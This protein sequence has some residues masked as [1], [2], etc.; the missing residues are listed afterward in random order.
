LTGGVVVVDAFT[1]HTIVEYGLLDYFCVGLHVTIKRAELTQM[2]A[3]LHNQRF[4]DEA[5]EWH[6]DLAASVAALSNVEFVPLSDEG[7][8]DDSDDHTEVR[9]GL[10]AALLAIERNVPLLADDRHCQQACLNVG[11]LPPTHAFGTDVLI[12]ALASEAVVTEDQRADSV[13]RQKDV[14]LCVCARV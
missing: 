12:D 4:C 1:L 5:G 3:E 14:E 7:E 6:R 8:C 13:L 9:Y 2:R 10:G 11:T